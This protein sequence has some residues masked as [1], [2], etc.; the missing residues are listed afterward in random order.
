MKTLI[1]VVVFAVL[2]GGYITFLWVYWAAIIEFLKGGGR[3]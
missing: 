1:I 3:K 2:A